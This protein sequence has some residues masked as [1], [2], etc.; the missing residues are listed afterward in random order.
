[1]LRSATLMLLV[2]CGG[3]GV[4][5]DSDPDP[6]NTTNDTDLSN[7]IN[8]TDTDT[9]TDTDP[10]IS[11]TTF[12]FDCNTVPP[13]EQTWQ[14]AGE[15]GQAEDFDIDMDGYVGVAYNGNLMKRNQAGDVQVI[16]PGV[17]GLTSGTR[18]LSTGDWVIN[19]QNSGT[20][21]LIDVVTGAQQVVSS[22]FTWPNGIEVDDN[23]HLF[24][25][26]F[27]AGRIVRLDPYNPGDN[28]V[29]ASG[30]NQAN[31][32][33]L[34]PDEQTLYSM[35]SWTATIF[36]MD[37]Q[38][39]GS[40]GPVRVIHQDNAGNY[41]GM[42]V[43]Y[44]GNIYWTNVLQGQ[45]NTSNIERIRPDGTGFEVVARLPSWY[46]PNIRF[47]HGIGGFDVLKLYASDRDAGR[48]FEIDIG[49]PGRGHVGLR[50]LP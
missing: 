32:I 29:L 38:P 17:G 21:T 33:A 2:G 40:W 19:D 46:V 11:T 22:A 24:I 39:D 31:G 35:E 34:S 9:D 45:G 12:P 14:A 48:L 3:R 26:D 49:V 23:D 1:M 5:I 50:P 36:A 4:L 20:V 44:C 13:G 47:G 37:K 27:S 10:T 8:D 43:D 6:S 7:T 30:L 15:Y 42:N 28:E 16:S 25:S 18:V 41:Q